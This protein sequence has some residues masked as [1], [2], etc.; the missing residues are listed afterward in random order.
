[1][2]KY[3]TKK[4]LTT[5][6][7][8]I[9]SSALLVFI[10]I[11][12]VDSEVNACVNNKTG[13]VRVLNFLGGQC[14]K[15]E[16]PL[17]WSITGPQGLQGLQ[18]EQGPV[19][20]QGESAPRGTGN[21][22]FMHEGDPGYFLKTDGTMWVSN[23]T[24]GWGGPLFTQITGP[25]ASLPIPVSDIVDWQYYGLVDKYGN[26]WYFDY[27]TGDNVWHNFGPLP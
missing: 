15:N 23:T 20:P 19:G 9:A 25:V 16:T 3:L 14:T 17:V 11:A 18:G 27:H 2:K 12:A 21:I 26:F 6:S 4:R 1:M 22:A 5:A 24:S 13:A 10:A 7:V 8:V